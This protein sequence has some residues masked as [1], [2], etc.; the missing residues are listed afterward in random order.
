MSE[1]NKLLQESFPITNRANTLIL[2]I[3]S[4]SLLASSISG[5][6][7]WLCWC[8]P[9]SYR[10]LGA[11]C[12]VYFL[13]LVFVFHPLKIAAVSHNNIKVWRSVHNFFIANLRFL[14][15]FFFSF[16]IYLI[17]LFRI[18]L[19]IWFNWLYIST[20]EEVIYE[21]GLFLFLALFLSNHF[22]NYLSN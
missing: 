9:W 6:C 21:K 8:Y 11:R 17:N 1:G 15:L 5:S 7:W 13:I 20:M 18:F 10:G 12:D 22:F 19:M 2:I 3:L 16:V 14:G 4:I